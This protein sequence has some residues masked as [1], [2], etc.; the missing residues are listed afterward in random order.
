MRSY[1]GVEYRYS[2][3]DPQNEKT[4][5]V[6]ANLL[7][8]RPSLDGLGY[9]LNFYAGGTGVD[10][11]LAVRCQNNDS[12]WPTVVQ[13]LR[14]LTLDQAESDE[15]SSEGL[16][17]LLNAEDD[18]APLGPH[19]IRFINSQKHKFQDAATGT[20]EVFFTSESDVNSWCV[21]WR[22]GL[23]LNYLSFDQG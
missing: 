2:S 14:L 15:S 3:D 10:D 4:V 19:C 9:S 21:V 16:R 17:W 20:S 22:S 23:Y 8:F 6:V 11:R 5:S 18:P 13:H 12:H 1:D 7:G